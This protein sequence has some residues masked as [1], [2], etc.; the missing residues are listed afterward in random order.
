MTNF[1][2]W[3]NTKIG[4][5]EKYKFDTLSSQAQL[6]SSVS[7]QQQ[8]RF[9]VQLLFFV[10]IF[11]DACVFCSSINVIILHLLG[12]LLWQSHIDTNSC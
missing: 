11:F 8:T 1:K 5:S 7:V 6:D 2:N 9:S 12:F 10:C 4:I 3:Y